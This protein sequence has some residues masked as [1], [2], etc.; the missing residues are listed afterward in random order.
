MGTCLAVTKVI[1]T[2]TLGLYTGIT[3]ANISH[4]DIFVHVLES[5]TV[6]NFNEVNAHLKSKIKEN[7]VILSVLGGISSIFF[8]LSYFKAPT[9]AQHPYLIYAS[10]VLPISSVVYGLI[11]RKE[12]IK[13]FKLDELIKE[14]RFGVGAVEVLKKQKKE[15]AISELD[16]SVYKDLGSDDSSSVEGAQ[17][18]D[19]EITREVEVHLNKTSSENLVKKLGLANKIVGG[20]SL[21]GFV[22]ASVGIY[23]DF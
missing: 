14:W 18:E 1:G 10:L 20:V 4:Y 5:T 9:R 21:V 17:Q 19:E 16:N 12:L 22:I 13:F 6:Q 3:L 7:G 15:Q 2:T 8:Q 11:S 23:G